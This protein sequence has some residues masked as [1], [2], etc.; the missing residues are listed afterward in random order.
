MNE[1]KLETAVKMLSDGI[2]FG[3]V[4]SYCGVHRAT[5]KKYLS[6]YE[7]QEQE[8]DSTLDTIRTANVAR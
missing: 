4:A 6:L 3:I 2:S 1:L 8:T 7:L 5:L